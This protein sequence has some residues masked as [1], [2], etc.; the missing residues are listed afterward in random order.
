MT[1]LTPIH[2]SV[3]H[4]HEQ[5]AAEK[6]SNASIYELLLLL[7]TIGVAAFAAAF[8]VPDWLT[9]ISATWSGEK[10]RIYWYLGRSTAFVSFFWLWVSMLFGLLMSNRITRIWPS[11]PTAYELHQ[12]ASLLGL[13]FAVFHALVLMGSRFLHYD[14]LDVFIPFHS[15]AYRPESVALGQI[16][17]YAMVI[18]ALSFYV[19]RR[20]ITPA[21]WRAVHFLSFAIFALALGHGIYT[22]S[23]TD[24]AWVEG[25]YAISGISVLMLSLYRLGRALAQVIQSITEAKQSLVQASAPLPAATRLSNPP[26]STKPKPTLSM[27][28][29]TAPAIVTQTRQSNMTLV[30]GSQSGRTEAIAQEIAQTLSSK[31]I[32]V[33]LIDGAKYTLEALKQTQCLLLITSTFGKGDAP[34]NIARFFAQLKSAPKSCAAHL[35]YSV[36]AIGDRQFPNFC[37]AGKDFDTR[38]SELGA[39]CMGDLVTCEA[40]EQAVQQGWLTAAISAFQS[41][42]IT[43]TAPIAPARAPALAKHPISAPALAPVSL[44]IPVA[45]AATAA[46]IMMVPTMVDVAARALPLSIEDTRPFFMPAPHSNKANP[47]HN[48][49]ANAKMFNAPILRN[50]NLHGDEASGTQTR[51][52]VFALLGS[53]MSHEPGDALGVLPV[54]D[55]ATVDEVIAAVKMSRDCYVPLPE[56]GEAPLSEA[57]MYQYNITRLTEAHIKLVAHRTGDVALKRLLQ[58]ERGESLK[59]VLFG[60][61]L[62]DLLTLYPNIFHSPLDFVAA[63]GKLQPRLYSISSSR[64]LYP[65]QAHLTVGVLRY[66]SYGRL[67]QGVCSSDLTRAGTRKTRPVFVHP[68]KNFR[69]PT[70]PNT[71][72]VMIGASTGIAPF[73][74]FLQERMVTESPGKNWLIF[75][76]RNVGDDFLYQDE[77]QQFQV[78]GTLNR[79]DVAF[80]RDQTEKVYVQHL[81]QKKAAKLWHWVQQG[82]HIYV[83]GDAANM[84]KSVETALLE[85]AMAVGGHSA[86][87]AQNWIAEMRQD[88]RYQR[89]VYGE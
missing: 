85:S 46:P 15:D 19:Q 68:Q 69:L 16:G 23:D 36:L 89:D 5:A 43:T 53:G 22:G 61:Q 87:T 55:A 39:R 40:G 82:A 59:D 74:A 44:P 77:L 13:I 78:R 73:R 4:A 76:C 30:F 81:I 70:D 66:Q 27:Q 42:P 83:C 71:P 51:H 49:Y 11:G 24:M 33:S 25:F 12:H 64:K 52:V 1:P 8:I 84:A 45:V 62:I 31:G 17:L 79:F 35:S 63:L 41:A 67:R 65:D 80:S 57:L 28:S 34:D 14:L 18:V 47:A 38:L 7:V 75:G 88:G 21:V 20:L 58:P 26:P 56:G 32:P 37:K 10:P 9:D 72:I 54:N 3:Q 6:T 86:E 60:R 48:K 50:A 2:N 29:P